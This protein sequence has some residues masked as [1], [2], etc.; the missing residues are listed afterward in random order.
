VL[1]LLIRCAFFV[2]VLWLCCFCFFS[3]WAYW[4]DCV[5]SAVVGLFLCSVVGDS[6]LSL[7]CLFF[8]VLL[9]ACAYC[10]LCCSRIFFVF[11]ACA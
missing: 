11:V 4:F 8:A 1:C 3:C 6:V 10:V 7:N 2:I 9:Y 5:V